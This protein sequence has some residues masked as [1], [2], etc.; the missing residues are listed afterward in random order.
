MTDEAELS[1]C[2]VCGDNLVNENYHG[3]GDFGLQMEPDE[4]WDTCRTC[5]YARLNG[6][7]I[8]EG[9]RL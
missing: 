9:G 6:I 4:H 3:L 7:V 8:D 2:P 1:D 5:G